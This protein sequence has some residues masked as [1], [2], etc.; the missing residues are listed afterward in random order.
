MTSPV[1]PGDTLAGK[2]LVDQVLGAGGMGVVVAAHH[3]HLDDK[4]AIKFLLEGALGNAEAVARFAAEAR[5]AVKIKSEHVAR[6]SDVG[7]LENGAPYMVMEYLEGEDLGARLRRD[8]PLPVE[9]AV[10]FVLQACE[11][12]AEAHGLGIVH[13]DLKPTNLFVIRRADGLLSV[14]V[15]DFGISKLT[16]L[17][18]SGPDMS[19]THTAAILGSPL[20][21]SPEQLESAKN[22]DARTDIWSIG[23]LFYELLTGRPPFDAETMPELVLKV[24]TKEPAPLRNLRPDA[25]AGLHDVIQRCLAKKRDDRFADV[26]ELALA[27]E[28]FAPLRAHES[29]RRVSRVVQTAR[30]PSLTGEASVSEIAGDARA[31]GTV[32]TWEQSAT[33]SL[34]G[35]KLWPALVAVAVAAAVG[36]GAYVSL[37]SG[38]SETATEDVPPTSEPAAASESTETSDPEREADE[39][40]EPAPAAIAVE[41]AAEKADAAASK[42]TVEPK[43]PVIAKPT[44]R[45][46]VQKRPVPT[47]KPAATKET[48]PATTSDVFGD[49]K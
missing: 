48:P 17:G 3:I 28:P 15:L 11:A 49:R 43:K 27:L 25:P 16:K 36:I 33:G 4:V 41:P 38:G 9:Q 13:R 30:S 46:P 20:Y 42:P 7:N 47:S 1:Q 39:Q 23:V 2:Y 12:I 45:R 14:K 44:V 10:E 21:M 34:G 5:A 32:S 26:A 35:R 8:G 18:G 22:V 29:V 6:V 40:N 24:V 19:L 37:S 31:V